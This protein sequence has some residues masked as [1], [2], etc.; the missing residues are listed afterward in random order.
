MKRKLLLFL[1]LITS[2]LV[3]CQEVIFNENGVNNS[4][5][6]AIFENN[7]YVAGLFS[8]NIYKIN[9]SSQ[10]EKPVVILEGI[11]NPNDI[12]IN[13]GILYISLNPN[14]TNLDKIIK[15][16]LNKVNPIPEDIVSIPN[17]DGITIYNNKIYV[18]SGKDIFTI[19][20]SINNPSPVLLLKDVTL[21]YATNG[22]CIYNNSLY[23]TNDA[24]GELV[25]YDLNSSTPSKKVLF[26]NFKGRGLTVKNNKIYSTGGSPTKIFEIDP[27]NETF[28]EIAESNIPTGWDIITNTNSIFISNLEGGE[29]LKFDFANLSIENFMSKKINIFP[30]PTS[31][32]IEFSVIFQ[33][34]EI[35]I[36]DLNG[37]VVKKMKLKNSN[38]LNISDLQKGIYIIQKNK[39]RI[40]KIIKI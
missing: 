20:L 40:G 28:I 31:E 27:I 18:S 29:V 16:D 15:L 6:L 3:H 24:I 34:T 30:N 5:G 12:E 36:Y 32:F 19:D 39:E 14:N 9:L 21:S 22:I 23:A 17:P 26:D 38:K 2:I 1:T 33:N 35:K 4:S 7:L 10:N 11:S 37:R 8:N 13:E 25:K